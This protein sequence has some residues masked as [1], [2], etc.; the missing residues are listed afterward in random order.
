MVS[1]V[2]RGVTVFQFPNRSLWVVIAA[3]LAGLAAPPGPASDVATGAFA[4]GGAVWGYGELT[5]GVNPWRRFLG[6]VAL[7]IAGRAAVG[8]ATKLG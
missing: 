5:A 4:A 8:L 1:A 3:S 2:I 6:V 7:A